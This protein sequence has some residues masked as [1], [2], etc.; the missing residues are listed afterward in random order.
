MRLHFSTAIDSLLSIALLIKAIATFSA[1][2]SVFDV[3][4]IVAFTCYASFV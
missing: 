2:D 1:S 4:V 3:I